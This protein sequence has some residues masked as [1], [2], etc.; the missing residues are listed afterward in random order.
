MT[1]SHDGSETERGNSP[2]IPGNPLLGGNRT[3]ERTAASGRELK[4][5]QIV[6]IGTG[7]IPIP[8]RPGRYV[9]D[10]DLLRNAAIEYRPIE[11]VSLWN[12]HA[13]ACPRDSANTGRFCDRGT[14]FPLTWK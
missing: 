10:F 7:T 1:L 4:R 9:D 5:G 14:G 6:T 2:R 11:L 8:P 13:A 12:G 3:G